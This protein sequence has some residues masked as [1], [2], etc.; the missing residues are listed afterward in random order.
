MLLEK[1]PQRTHPAELQ[2]IEA[3]LVAIGCD[4]DDETYTQ[5]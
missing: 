4:D 1:R 3:H 5:H 2:E